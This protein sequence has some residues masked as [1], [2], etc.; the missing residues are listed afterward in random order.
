MNR[1]AEK[2]LGEK[3]IREL[4]SQTKATYALYVDQGDRHEPVLVGVEWQAGRDKTKELIENGIS[5]L[6][7]YGESDARIGKNFYQAA[8]HLWLPEQ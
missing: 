3:K 8:K 7:I 2:Q 6:D 1:Y 4:G 5:P